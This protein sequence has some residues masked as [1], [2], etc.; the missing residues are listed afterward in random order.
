MQHLTYIYLP[1][2]NSAKLRVRA[3]IK[4]VHKSIA[5]ARKIRYTGAMVVFCKIAGELVAFA[6]TSLHFLFFPRI[7]IA[8]ETKSHSQKLKSTA[9]SLWVGK[10]FDLD[11]VKEIFTT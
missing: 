6:A 8:K 7:Q 10:P 5:N 3:L 1:Q 11:N 4:L 2:L 9:K